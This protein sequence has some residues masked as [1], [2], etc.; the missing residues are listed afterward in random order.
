ME[1][2]VKSY[3]FLLYMIRIII[4][5][6][7]EKWSNDLARGILLKNCTIPFSIWSVPV[8]S[9]LPSTRSHALKH[10][11]MPALL[12]WTDCV[13]VLHI[14]LWQC[15]SALTLDLAM[16]FASV[17]GT[18]ANL[19]QVE[20]YVFLL[21]LL[22]LCLHLEIMPGLPYRKRRHMEQTYVSVSLAEAP[23]LQ[24]RPDKIS[25]APKDRFSLNQL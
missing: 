23:D 16:L 24:N 25:K 22:L 18:T 17:N 14:S 15:T 10:P 8:P 9:P 20:T 12:A 3:G 4:L 5:G 2:S 21:L 1:T 7:C 11:C 6:N 19:V 13:P